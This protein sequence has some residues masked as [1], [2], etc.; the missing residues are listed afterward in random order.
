MNLT[1]GKDLLVGFRNEFGMTEG[2]VCGMTTSC[3]AE[4][5]YATRAFAL[6]KLF[7]AALACLGH[8]HPTGGCKGLF[9]VPEPAVMKDLYIL[10]LHHQECFLISFFLHFQVFL[11]PLSL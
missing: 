1:V 9:T 7:N 10:Q 5:V 3:H 6:R 4:L 2:R 11:P 8:Q